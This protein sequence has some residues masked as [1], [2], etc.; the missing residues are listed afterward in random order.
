LR[1]CLSSDPVK[2]QNPAH[3]K[4]LP[5]YGLHRLDDS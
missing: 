1:N 5:P 4:M 2:I 3:A